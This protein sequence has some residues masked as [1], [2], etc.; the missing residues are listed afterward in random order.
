MTQVSRPPRSPYDLTRGLLYFARMLD[1]IRLQ[2]AGLLDAAYHSWL[3]KGF[4]G[5]LCRLLGVPYEV[6]VARVRQGGTDE[7]ILSWCGEQGRP[8]DEELILIWNG[9]ASK[10]GW[11]DEANGGTA[12]LEAF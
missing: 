6:V 3:G 8:L 2:D 10:R 7:E 4:D 12:T 9:F 11:R 1:K 5:R